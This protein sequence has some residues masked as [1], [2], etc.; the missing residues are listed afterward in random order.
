M[1]KDLTV[2]KAWTT[3]SAEFLSLLICSDLTEWGSEVPPVPKP[4]TKQGKKRGTY[5]FKAQT[6]PSGEQ[7]TRCPQRLRLQS[8]GAGEIIP[9]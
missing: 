7:L 2:C 1:Y 4:D 3:I 8:F 6:V 5:P 9:N